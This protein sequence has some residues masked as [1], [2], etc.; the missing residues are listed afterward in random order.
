MDMAISTVLLMLIM[1]LYTILYAIHM[2][3]LH[4][5]VTHIFSAHKVKMQIS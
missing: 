4:L 5:A 2:P 1:N 3:N